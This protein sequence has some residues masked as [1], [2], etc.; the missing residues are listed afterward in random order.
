MAIPPSITFVSSFINIYDKPYDKRNYEWRIERFKEVAETGILICLYISPCFEEELEKIIAVY[1][2]IRIVKTVNIKESWIYRLFT[3][4]DFLT[5]PNH[6]HQEKDTIEYLTLMN[7]KLDFLK[8]TIEQNPWQTQ[9][10]GWIDFNISYIFKNIRESQEYLRL[11]S[12]VDLHGK[13]VCIPGCWPKLNSNNVPTIFNQTHWRFCGGFLIGDKESILEMHNLYEKHFSGFTKESKKILWEVNFWSWLDSCT[14]WNPVWFQADHNESMLKIPVKYMVKTVRSKYLT[15]KKYDYPKNEYFVPVS[16]SYLFYDNKRLLNTRFINYEIM[17]NGCYLYKNG[18]HI[19]ENLNY[20]SE[21]DNE[22]IPKNYH[23]MNEEIDLPSN[24]NCFSQ[25]LEDIRLFN[26]QNKVWFIATNVNYSPSNKNRMIIGEYDIERY[27]YGNC[28]IIEPPYNTSCEKNWI[29][30][31]KKNQTNNNGDDELFFIYKWHPYEI[32][33]LN[34]N[35]LEI[36]TQMDVYSP[37]F[38]KIRG[39]TIFS[40]D[41]KNDGHLLGL[42]H[43]SETTCPRQ[44]FH[45]LVILDKDTFIPIKYSNIFCFEQYSIEFCIGFTI[46][47]DKYNFW[48]SRMDKDPVLV[49]LNESAFEFNNEIKLGEQH[50]FSKEESNIVSAQDNIVFVMETK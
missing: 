23:L 22:F 21:L 47:D 7:L 33:K 18:K 37:F 3:E 16:A 27:K 15:T 39:S 49:T 4:N 45:L 46:D 48:I 17:A 25:G 14:D 35:K 6:R 34:G 12:Q 24:Q 13:F 32:G 11:Y 38:P 2:N 26:Y 50:I 31:V 43:F 9:Y 28:Q 41:P 20:F 8:D 42:V 1:P 44:Y 5:L 19:I 36:I 30:L 10:F 40:P 29:P